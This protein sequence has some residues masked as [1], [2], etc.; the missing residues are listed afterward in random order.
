VK[1]GA[2]LI[3]RLGVYYGGLMMD[4][5]ANMDELKALARNGLECFILLNGGLRSSK[6]VYYDG[7]TWFVYNEIDDTEQELPGERGLANGTNIVEAL[8]K[9]ALWR[10]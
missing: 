4:R 1:G 6:H 8:G 5:I 10:F 7:E 9:G 2:Q 3:F